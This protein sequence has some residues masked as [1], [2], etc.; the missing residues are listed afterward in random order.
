MFSS[1]RLIRSKLSGRFS[2]INGVRNDHNNSHQPAIFN[3]STKLQ[4]LENPN[5]FQKIFLRFK[6]V[7]LKG[8]LEPPKALFDDIGKK[9]YF[10]QVP[11][12]PKDFKE[13]PE[14]DLV[15]FP[16]PERPHMPPKARFLLIPDQ[17]CKEIEKITGT[18]G[19]YLFIGTAVAF[20]FN[21][22]MLTLDVNGTYLIFS[23]IPFYL[24]LRHAFSY[25]VDKW[26]YEM[27]KTANN[28][29]KDHIQSELR[30]AIDF[31]KVSS[32]EAGSLKAV[33]ENFPTIFHE[34]LA[35]QLEATY[36]KNIDYAWDELKRRLDYLQEV[37]ETKERFAKE[38]LLKT[39]IEGVRK[40]IETN[41]GD[42]RGKYMDQCIEQLKVLAK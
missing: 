9:F 34:N 6:G 26:F 27:W 28:E 42:I 13:F 2:L 24:L 21:R 15:N 39:I 14:R 25:R 33:Q 8:E 17:W 20:L 11:A 12:V 29:R 1:S 23:W 4:E 22:E 40:Q 35:L 31:K 36:R 32:D 16:Y 18:S 5:F 38:M 10:E 19:P 37:Q 7:A 41:E 3:E 30:E